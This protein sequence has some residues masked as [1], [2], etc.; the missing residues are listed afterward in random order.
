MGKIKTEPR[1][2]IKVKLLCL[3]CG[4]NFAMQVNDNSFNQLNVA[5][6]ESSCWICQHCIKNGNLVF[7]HFYEIL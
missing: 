7:Y 6:K 5:N 2:T 4:D 3:N 1:K